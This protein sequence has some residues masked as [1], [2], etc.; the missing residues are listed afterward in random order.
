M[1]D[2]T[3]DWSWEPNPP[4]QCGDTA[5]AVARD[6]VVERPDGVTVALPDLTIVNGAFGDPAV[7]G[8]AP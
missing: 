6:L 3:I 5:T 1:I 2:G 4:M 7:N 8:C